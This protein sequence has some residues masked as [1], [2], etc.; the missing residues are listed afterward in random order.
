MQEYITH[1]LVRIAWR[2]IGGND[3][4]IEINSKKI[5]IPIN[6]NSLKR[7]EDDKVKKHIQNNIKDYY[8]GLSVDKHVFVK[9]EFVMAIECKAYTENAMLKRILVDFDFL[10]SIKKD[11]R[12][13]L[14]QLESQLGGDYSN[15][16]NGIVLGSPSTHTIMS[17]F[18]CK[19][20][21]ITLLEGERR[22]DK[23]IHKKQ[24]YKRLHKSKLNEA[25]EILKDSL[26]DFK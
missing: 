8:Y 24:F 23:P 21:I 1:S 16:Q 26:K 18:G 6:Q 2:E 17:Y 4:D 13:F 7:I 19:L 11:L 14:F 9:G 12:C 22:V 3:D 25:K 15:P 5:K 10:K 20:N